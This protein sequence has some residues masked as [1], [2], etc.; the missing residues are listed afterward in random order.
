[1]VEIEVE[2]DTD[3]K[4]FNMV[5]TLDALKQ[6]CEDYIRQFDPHQDTDDSLPF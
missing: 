5:T 6:K 3:D 4:T 2:F 1:M